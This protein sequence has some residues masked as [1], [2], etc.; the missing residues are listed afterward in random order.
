MASGDKLING[1]I[2]PFDE[3]PCRRCGMTRIAFDDGSRPHCTGRG[4][5]PV[6]DDDPPPDVEPFRPRPDNGPDRPP[7]R[8]R[9]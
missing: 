9:S 3:S 8:R 4:A 2:F 7:R 1:H 6:P 5:M